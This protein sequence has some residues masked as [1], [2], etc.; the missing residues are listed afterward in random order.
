MSIIDQNLLHDEKIVHR[1]RHHRAVLLVQPCVFF[2]LSLVLYKT[3]RGDEGTVYFSLGLIFTLASFLGGVLRYFSFEAVIS[4]RRVL[5]QTGLLSR[6][7]NEI[8]FTK[9]EAIDVQQ[10]PLGRLLDYGKIVITGT[11]GSKTSMLFIPQPFAFRKVLQQQAAASQ[12][13]PTR[14]AVAV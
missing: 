13:H 2:V 7:C 10:S 9:A 11:G 3:I 4:T 5:T 8:L 6:Q 12:A 1:T 14:Q